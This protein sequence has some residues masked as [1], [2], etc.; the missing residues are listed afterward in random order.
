MTNFTLTADIIDAIMDRYENVYGGS[1]YGHNSALSFANY[2]VANG[3][4]GTVSDFID[5]VAS[6]LWQNE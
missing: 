1:Y 4:T 6:D 5:D 2:T 3:F